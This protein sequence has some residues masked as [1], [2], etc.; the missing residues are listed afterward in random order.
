MV[1]E[2]AERKLQEGVP[3]K[4]AF[5]MAAKKMFVPVVSA[6]FTTLGAF[7]PLLF[8]PGI[9]GKFMS[10]L[11]IIV[12][13]V[14]CASLL[15]ALIFMP[16]IGAHHRLAR[17]STRRPRKRPTSSCIP[18]SSTSR[19]SGASTGIYVRTLARLLH[20]PIITLAVGFAHRHRDLRRLHGQPDR[21]PRPSR[22]PSPSSARSTV[23]ARGNYSPVEIRDYLVEVEQRDPAG[24]GHPGRHHDVRRR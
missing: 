9:I 18:T 22:R 6:T 19:R 2:Y 12:I 17:M 3:K 7:I 1:V 11:P 16:I 14:M 8:W 4:E 21:H 10:Y 5:I 24:P 23:V 20:H 13:V 15:S